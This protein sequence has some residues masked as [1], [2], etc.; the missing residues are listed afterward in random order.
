MRDFQGRKKWHKIFRSDV[1]SFILLVATILLL[2]SVWGV[3]KKDSMARINMKEAEIT[4]A[5]LEKKKVGLEKEIAKLNTERGIE[6]ELRRRFQV[7]KPG[8][9]VLV[10]VDKAEGNIPVIKAKEGP[11]SSMWNKLVGLVL[12]WK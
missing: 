12:F 4:L 8:E 7:V 2:K 6:E 5:N 3:Y 9:Q 10:V 11:M 1:F